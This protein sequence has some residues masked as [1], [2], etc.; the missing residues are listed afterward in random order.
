MSER[1][2]EIKKGLIVVI[3][4][5]VVLIV[6]YPLLMS[7][8]YSLASQDDRVIATIDGIKPVIDSLYLLSFILG[9]FTISVMLYCLYCGEENKKP[10]L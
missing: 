3:I 8:A 2:K 10:N 7:S 9:S 6:S 5:L 4:L 1:M